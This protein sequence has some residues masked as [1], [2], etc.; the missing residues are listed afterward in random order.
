MGTAT[1]S[2]D[3]RFFAA[4]YS[5]ISQSRAFQRQFDP[6]RRELTQAA[7][8]VVLEVGAGGGQNFG[9]YDPNITTRVEAVEPNAYMLARA[10]EAAAKARVSIHLTSAPAEQLPFADATFDT[11]LATLV[12][13][14]VDDPVRGI[15]EMRRV[16]KPG[17]VL[18]LFE[19]VRS[20]SRGWARVQD[21]LTPLQTRF[22]GNCHLNRPT[23]EIVRAQG[24]AMQN[25]IWSGGAVHP[26]VV[27]IATKPEHSAMQHA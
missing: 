7:R 25:E 15:Q 24:F 12:F 2:H 27:I 17:G 11:A 21:W 20:R 9:F 23:S 26:I 8:G 5:R 22:A 18:L 16:L 13:C 4:C 19:H 3:D 10:Q 14:S 1:K 6:F